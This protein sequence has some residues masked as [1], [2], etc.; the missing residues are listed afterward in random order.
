MV[1]YYFRSMPTASTKCITNFKTGCRSQGTL[2]NTVY[3]QGLT[4]KQTGRKT[5]SHRWD[6][7]YKKRQTNTQKGRQIHRKTDKSV[8]VIHRKTD[9]YIARQTNAQKDRQIR[10]NT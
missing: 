8:S 4:D 9:K 7:R 10:R 1:I 2:P 3:C 6:C 5:D